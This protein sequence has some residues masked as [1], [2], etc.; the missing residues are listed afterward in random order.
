MSASNPQCNLVLTFGVGA[1][2]LWRGFV[3]AAVGLYA[4]EGSPVQVVDA[5]SFGDRISTTLAVA[6]RPLAPLAWRHGDGFGWRLAAGLGLQA[7][8]SIELA[9]TSLDQQ[10]SVGFHGA[11]LLD[12][13][14]YGGATMGGLALR[15]SGRVLVTREARLA[16]D[17]NKGVFLVDEPGTAL[18]LLVGFAYYL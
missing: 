10:T 2:A 15:L 5:P 14:I 16:F 1:E 3:G 9:R 18:Q 6:I 13:P 4:A 7:G 8:L 17:T 11:A 12:V